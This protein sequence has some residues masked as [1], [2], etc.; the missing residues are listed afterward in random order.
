M[1]AAQERPEFKEKSM[2]HLVR[3]MTWNI[4]EGSLDRTQ[5][6]NSQLPLIAQRIREQRPDLVLLN[7][8][9]NWHWPWAGG[10]N[11]VKELMRLGSWP[12]GHWGKTAA[13][14]WAGY[15]AVAV[16]S[17]RPLGPVTMHPVMLNQ[18][19]TGYATL[20]TS[21]AIKG[22]T[23]HL[24][25][26]R[27]NAHSESEN[28]AG[29]DQL[30]GMMGQLPPLDGVIA[31]GD[32][33]AN[34][35]R[36]HFVDFAENSG[37]RHAGIEK[38]DDQPCDT[39]PID[40]IF[41]RG[42]YA[43][44]QTWIRCPQPNPSD[45]VWVLAEL[46]SP[47][48][49]A[50]VMYGSTLTIRHWATGGHLH[51]HP[52]NYGHVGSSGQQQVTAFL[53][54]DDNDLWRIKPRH[55]SREGAGAGPVSHGDVIRLEHIP[56]RRNLHSHLGYP[57]PVTGQQEVTS[58]GTNGQGDGNDDWRVEVKN[59]DYLSLGGMVK[60]VHGATNVALHS[61][62]GF[63]HPQWTQGQQEVTGFRGRDDN[64]WWYV[65]EVD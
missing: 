31:A 57:S 22:L 58:F 48:E 24:F 11:Q 40:H 30:K 60:F 26:V 7:E 33:N 56:T 12:Y 64:D 51:S 62:Y 50:T 42:N 2:P 35:D 4:A 38:P 43:V 49:G 15:K 17:R 59:D 20:H 54:S 25:S 19:T 53:G 29:I 10:V 63:N 41:L 1:H 55:G 18:T 8:V 65:S 13:T 9:K 5:P 16:L 21:V 52:Y 46:Q 37:L 34:F 14:G 39:Q 27:F 6:D 45:H 61:H 44:R 36:P 32:F 3:V 47:P 28:V 23:H